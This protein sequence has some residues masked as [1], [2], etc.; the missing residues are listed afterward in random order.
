L[1]A[2]LV[3]ETARAERPDFMLGIDANYS[4]EMEAKG[5]RWR[6]NSRE[7]DLFADPEAKFL[8]HIAHWWDAD[9]CIAFF[10]FMSRPRI[11]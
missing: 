8:L 3:S 2:L 5:S 1:L 7:Q 10:K 11:D 6:W 4:L 9:F